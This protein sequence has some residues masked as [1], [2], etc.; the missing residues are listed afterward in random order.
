[1]RV[2]INEYDKDYNTITDYL[3]KEF[4]NFEQAELWCEENSWSGYSYWIDRSLTKA[5]NK[6]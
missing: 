3:E 6:Q 4:D 5:V 2:F 1:M